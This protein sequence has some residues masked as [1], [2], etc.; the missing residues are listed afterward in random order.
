[1][2]PIN[3]LTL[4]DMLDNLSLYIGLSDGLIKLPVPEYF[5]IKKK[6]TSHPKGSERTY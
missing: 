6:E 4:H 3:K 1:M 2:I 5:E